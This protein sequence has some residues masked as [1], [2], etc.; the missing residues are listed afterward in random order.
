MSVNSIHSI[1]LAL[2]SVRAMDE[3]NRRLEDAG[4]RVS[5]GRRVVDARENSASF[6][7]AQQVR[8]QSAA[9]N[10]V[11]READVTRGLLKTAIGGAES[12]GDL[13]TEMRAKALAAQ[14]PMMTSAQRKL[15][16]LDLFNLGRQVD[17]IAYDSEFLGRNLLVPQ[18][19]PIDSTTFT[20]DSAVTVDNPGRLTAVDYDG[21][22]RTDVLATTDSNDALLLRNSGNFG[23]SQTSQLT[24]SGGYYENDVITVT[25]DGVDYATTLSSSTTSTY[26]AMSQVRSTLASVPGVASVTVSTSGS[27]DARQGILSV[28]FDDDQSHS[29][30]V[31][32]SDAERYPHDPSYD[33]LSRAVSNQ[34][35]DYSTAA[36]SFAGGYHENDQITV[37][38]DGVPT[39]VTLAANT[40]GDTNLTDM[41][42][43]V[44][45]AVVSANAGVTGYSLATSGSGD[46]ATGTLTLT[47]DDVDAHSAAVGVSE[48]N[49]Y[50]HESSLAPVSASRST[51]TG[52]A[53]QAQFTLSGTFDDSDTLT[54]SAGSITAT[55]DMTGV[56]TSADPLQETANRVRD[57]FSGG[58]DVASAAV[59]MTS[60][61]GTATALVDIDFNHVNAISVTSSVTGGGVPAPSVTETS[62]TGTAS[63]GGLQ[64]VGAFYPHDQVTV[65]I[66]GVSTTVTLD[67]N[68]AGGNQ[69]T[70]VLSQVSTAI[71]GS[72]SGV[73]AANPVVSDSGATLTGDLDLTF[74]DGDSHSVSISVFDANNTPISGSATTTQG[75]V[76]EV[77]YT[78]GGAFF[79]NDTAAIYL[80]GQWLSVTLDAAA[81]ASGD[82]LDYALDALSTEIQ[83][84]VANV[85]SV[86]K[87]FSG[88]DT[89][90]EGALQV[91]FDNPES[92]SAW[93][94]NSDANARPLSATTTT[95]GGLYD[96]RVIAE[97]GGAAS[98]FLAADFDQDGDDDLVV[99]KTDSA[100]GV[101]L[102]GSKSEYL[103]NSAPGTAYTLRLG[104]S[105]YSGDAVTVTVD[106]TATTV[107]LDSDLDTGD[108]LPKAIDQ[109]AEGLKTAFPNLIASIAYTFSGSGASRTGTL[110]LFFTD[111]ASHDITATFTDSGN[112]AETTAFSA[113]ILGSGLASR[114][115]GDITGMPA[116][117]LVNDATY[118]LD[119]QNEHAVLGD[120]NNDGLDDVIKANASG[121]LTA[122]LSNGDGSFTAGATSTT[123]G[124]LSGHNGFAVGDIDMDGNLDVAVNDRENNKVRLGFGDGA[125]NFN[126]TH[127]VATNSAPQHSHLADLNGDLIPDLLVAQANQVQTF[128]GD[129]YGN[130]SQESDFATGGTITQNSQTQVVDLNNDGEKDFIA[131]MPGDGRVEVHQRFEDGSYTLATAQTGLTQPGGVLATDL[132]GDQAPDLVIADHAGG[133]TGEV[134][135]HLNSDP[136]VVSQ[137]DDVEVLVSDTGENMTISHAPMALYNLGIDPDILATDPET[138]LTQID[139]ALENHAF[140]LGRLTNQYQR[141][142]QFTNYATAMADAATEALGDIVDANIP[143]ETAKYR[144][145]QL[146]HDLSM[147]SLPIVN[148]ATNWMLG[149]FRS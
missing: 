146:R 135:I 106:G 121:Q 78:L 81:D 140:K 144:A 20:L 47:F 34:P 70:E 147:Q 12:I 9:F 45:A 149:L 29:L 138:A 89:S 142:S 66:D 85:A 76:T 95:D 94:Y 125:G 28:T 88:S 133:A 113:T 13:L 72:F 4:K 48:A 50:D 69:M 16:T 103:E 15:M 111:D 7:L 97:T 37:T 62:T 110:E 91:V 40:S 74:D 139:A 100:V 118:G 80:D 79:P 1:A 137:M 67:G 10:V 30:S 64:L 112:G 98:K 35:G 18:A 84:N 108:R 109:I 75:F 105:F 129:L 73:T 53:T 130:F 22:G 55:I 21:D 83:N 32:L 132:N 68:T 101:P 8:G 124:G 5:S 54:V 46:S 36:L 131:S 82:A 114:G 90:R 58:A 52:S 49:D 148:Q 126:F 143:T 11:R 136:T 115:G 123:P 92:V 43:Q 33:P 86:T 2:Q 19:A 57:A 39:V 38:L 26:N 93:S 42:N 24:F 120:V 99:T 56:A 44:G 134:Q 117:S 14:D 65:T 60:V 31:R 71:A 122:M 6:V 127:E 51:T 23:V 145:A 27:G 25:V 128:L 107:T 96:Q 41:L 87:S 141:F 104:G 77:T 116:E 119:G 3:Q 17:Q 59:T 61:S 63:S 102:A